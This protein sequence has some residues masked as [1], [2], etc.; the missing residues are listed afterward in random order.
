MDIY[1]YRGETI[2]ELWVSMAVYPWRLILAFFSWSAQEQAI[3][4][5]E[6]GQ[7]GSF[8]LQPRNLSQIML[9]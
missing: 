7:N 9:A 8:L 6:Y 5:I 1:D 4:I 2:Y 3:K